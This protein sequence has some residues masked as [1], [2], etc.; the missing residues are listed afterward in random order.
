MGEPVAVEDRPRVQGHRLGQR[1]HDRAGN[2][3]ADAVGEDRAPVL[4]QVVGGL[5]G[6]DD[7]VVRP[8][9][10]RAE[11]AQQLLGEVDPLGATSLPLLASISIPPII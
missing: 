9:R 10:P 4:A 11:S 6:S 3:E 7:V 2:G 1:P 5:V 8:S